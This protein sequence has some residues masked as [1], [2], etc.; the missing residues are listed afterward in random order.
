MCARRT[1]RSTRSV[2]CQ[3]WYEPC[4]TLD[5]P[6]NHGNQP[7]CSASCCHCAVLPHLQACLA[8]EWL[9]ARLY[10]KLQAADLLFQHLPV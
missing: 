3:A 4:L 8:Y 10:D 2:P 5:A 9:Q 6:L 7:K 1:S